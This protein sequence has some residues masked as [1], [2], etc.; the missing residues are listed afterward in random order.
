MATENDTKPEKVKVAI[1]LHVIGDE[2]IEVYNA[3]TWD[4]KETVEGQ[5]EPQLVED[6]KHKLEYVLK[7]LEDYCSPKKNVVVERHK[8]FCRYQGEGE[9]IER[10]LT[11]LKLLAQNCEFE[12]L[13]TS[14]IMSQVVRG[15]RDDLVR[16]KLLRVDNLELDKAMTICRAAELVRQQAKELSS[17]TSADAAT[18]ST[19]HAVKKQH[20]YQ[21]KKRGGHQKTE[22]RSQKYSGGAT[23]RNDSSRN[24]SARS[25][26]G[27]PSQ[28]SCGRC[29]YKHAPNRCPAYNQYCSKCHRRGHFRKCCK[30]KHVDVVHDEYEDYDYNSGNE[31][32]VDAIYA[33]NTSTK[34]D[35]IELLNINGAIV[36]CKLDTGAQANVMSLEEY[37]SLP[38]KPKI[39]SCSAKLTGYYNSEIPLVG[40]CITSI[41]HRGTR[42]KVQF[43]VVPGKAPT[44]LGRNACEKLDLVRRVEAVQ[45][46]AGGM[47]DEYPDIFQ[48]LGCLPGE[49]NIALKEDAVPMVEACRKVPFKMQEP[50]KEELMK[51]VKMGIIE[52]VEEPSDWV[53]APHVVYKPNG[54]LRVCMDPRHLNACIKREHFKLPTREEI[55]SNFAGAKIF[56][57]LDATKGFWQLKLN[58]AS[59]KLCTFITPFGRFRYLRLP[60]GI[61]SAPEIY[62][63]TVHNLFAHIE[64]VNTSMDDV[65]ISGSSFEEH[66]Q[67]L[68]EVLETCRKSG[69]KL[70]RDKCEEGVNEL[71]FLGENISDE[72]VKPDP[73]KTDAIS[74]FPTPD[75]KEALQRLLG[76]V[77]YLGRFLPDLSTRTHKMRQLLKQDVVFSWEKAHEEEFEDMK[78]LVLSDRVLQFHDPEL[79]MK[80][81][82]DSSKVGLGAVLQQKSEGE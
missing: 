14:L 80:V 34:T 6:Q 11:E 48:G 56:T 27:Q 67:R 43:M 74:K 69:F 35:W 59:S 41:E 1:L 15:I 57:K 47:L 39:T 65:I 33:V 58:E 8:F 63:R 20:K 2:G 75:S 22:A 81:S 25:S 5:D 61:S 13:E 38:D 72:G 68:K 30:A 49:V 24:D 7:K 78:R 50:L 16:E 36:P 31:L 76:M 9:S 29:G 42:F 70:N 46:S 19:V 32:V 26:S 71:T 52:P 51:M 64:G 53:N 12:Q 21:N 60:F 23:S 3:F 17:S 82:A 62:H 28:S 79:P 40:K 73:K 18:S 45:R 10:Y 77:N 37:R 4:Y 44:L 55:M 54:Q 66:D